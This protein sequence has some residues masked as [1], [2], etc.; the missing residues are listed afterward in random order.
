MSTQSTINTISEQIDEYK[1]SYECKQQDSRLVSGV[2]TKD[3][4]TMFMHHPQMHEPFSNLSNIQRHYVNSNC[5]F[6]IGTLLLNTRKAVQYFNNNPVNT[7]EPAF[8]LLS[9]TNDESKLVSNYIINENYDDFNELVC[10]YHHNP[11]YL[12]DAREIFM[13]HILNPTFTMDYE[14]NLHFN[15]AVATYLD[16]AQSTEDTIFN[17]D[18]NGN[19]LHLSCILPT[20]SDR[21]QETAI[22]TIYSVGVLIKAVC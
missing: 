22:D 20:T 19:I 11:N 12:M 15:E 14:M 13:I 18:V 9:L 21:T 17:I 7:E 4:N 5:T 2:S 3:S 10:N 1:S 6:G 16:I 8:T